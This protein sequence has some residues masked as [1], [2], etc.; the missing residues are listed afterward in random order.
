MV[1][2]ASLLRPRVRAPPPA[3]GILV[4]REAEGFFA[5]SAVCTHLGCPNAAAALAFDEHVSHLVRPSLTSR[6]IPALMEWT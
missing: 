4:V 1:E 6:K 3:T 5:L 2:R